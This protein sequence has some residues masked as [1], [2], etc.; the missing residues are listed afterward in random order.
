MERR[1]DA[2]EGS[3]AV[4]AAAVVALLAVVGKFS[5]AAW[6]RV[7]VD[8]VLNLFFSTNCG[9]KV[10]TTNR[11]QDLSLLAVQGVE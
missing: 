2:L 10:Y 5:G 9:V 11:E 8:V 7:R 4:V 3:L 1:G 6:T